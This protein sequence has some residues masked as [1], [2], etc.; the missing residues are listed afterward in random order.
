MTLQVLF[1]GFLSINLI[2]KDYHNV[3]AYQCNFW[4]CYI[5]GVGKQGPHFILRPKRDFAVEQK[6]ITDKSFF[7]F[8]HFWCAVCEKIRSVFRSFITN[9]RFVRFSFTTDKDVKNNRRDQGLHFGHVCVFHVVQVDS[10]NN[11]NH[12]TTYSTQ[13]LQFSLITLYKDTTWPRLKINLLALI[14]GIFL[15]LWKGLYF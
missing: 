14:I 12:Q 9:L 11:L 1:F 15:F 10:Q 8:C 13:I 7:L 2:S 4:V 3:I 6:N 5:S